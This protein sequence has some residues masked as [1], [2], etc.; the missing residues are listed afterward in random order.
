MFFVLIKFQFTPPRK[1]RPVEHIGC[2]HI[3]GFNS[4]PHVRGDGDKRYIRKEY[5][6]FQFT[7]PR[8]G[9]HFHFCNKLLKKGFNSR[10]HVRGDVKINSLGVEAK[11]FNS[12]PHVRGD[13]A[14]PTEEYPYIKFQFTPPR[15]GRQICRTG[16]LLRRCFNSRPHV[17]GD[18]EFFKHFVG[19][20]FQ[21]TPPRKGRPV[22]SIVDMALI[23]V[24]IHAPT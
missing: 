8:K 7:P 16:N 18:M 3:Q 15:K 12:R 20:M 19:Y 17:R 1:G 2:V 22:S 9:R 6:L 21:F 13:E 11:G 23:E 24:S 14:E 4:R 10:P 5:A